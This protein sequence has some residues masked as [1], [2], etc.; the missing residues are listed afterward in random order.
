MLVLALGTLWMI[1]LGAW[2]VLLHVK[3]AHWVTATLEWEPWL[4]WPYEQFLF[5]A[6]TG[7]LIAAGLWAV[8]AAS[9]LFHAH[10][11]LPKLINAVEVE[12]T[13]ETHGDLLKDMKLLQ[14]RSGLPEGSVDLYIWEDRTV[15]NAFACG[16]SPAHGS[17][18]LSRGL[19]DLLT[20][21]ERLAVM[22]HELAH[23]NNRDTMC[24]VQAIAFVVLV[25]L[26]GFLGVLWAVMIVAVASAL[27]TLAVTLISAPFS[28]SSGGGGDD[29]GG[30]LIALLL[31][32]LGILA[33][34]KVISIALGLL[35]ACLLLFGLATLICAIGVRGV[36]SATAQSRE[37]LADACAAQW[38]NAADL[39]TALI[40]TGGHPQPVSL[41]GVLLKPLLF[42]GCSS[43]ETRT[44]LRTAFDWL[45]I[46][47]PDVE[48]RVDR[49]RLM[50]AGGG[51][52]ELEGANWSWHEWYAPV[53]LS[54]LLLAVTVWAFPKSQAAWNE[55]LTPVRPNYNSTQVTPAPRRF[56]PVSVDA[57]KLRQGPSETFQVLTVLRSGAP[58]EVIEYRGPDPRG[59]SSGVTSKPASRGHFKTGQLSAS[60]T[61]TFLPHR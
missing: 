49:L 24:I 14:V 10:N 41:K 31:F 4:H 38:T 17:I 56:T 19:L 36:S 20:R 8:V 48:E 29:A 47:H 61:V 15:V 46:T 13:G 5:R 9:L 7:V 55:W 60:R 57:V 18:I 43:D 37:H 23:L 26:F 42:K 52:S 28:D 33:L 35:I 3:M 1:S 2:G 32:M 12:A 40:K 34:V 21:N 16:L 22:A 45:Y 58:V 27:A 44:F 6:L 39:A 59:L 51:G 54:A 53:L 50:T 25:F 11:V 30:C